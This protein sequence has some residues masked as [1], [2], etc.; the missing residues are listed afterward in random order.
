[1]PRKRRNTR[2]RA[3]NKLKQFRAVATHHDKRGYVYL[4]TAT[5]ATLIIWLQ[6]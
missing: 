4:G 3:I 1:M 2:E 5:V 6:S